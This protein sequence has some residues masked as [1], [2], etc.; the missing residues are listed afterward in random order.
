[1]NQFI[2][3]TGPKANGK[4]AARETAINLIHR[5]NR[6]I[7]EMEDSQKILRAASFQIPIFGGDTTTQSL[8][9]TLSLNSRPRSRAVRLADGRTEKLDGEGV[10][11]IDADELSNLLGRGTHSAQ[12][13]VPFFTDV[14]FQDNNPKATKTGYYQGVGPLVP[15]R[16]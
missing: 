2:I 12:L 14:A 6:K 10:C 5:M 9:K 13:R 8:I 15:C 16:T 7:Q 1:M 3:L 11:G 4:S